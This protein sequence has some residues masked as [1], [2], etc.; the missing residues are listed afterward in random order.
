MIPLLSY[1]H[2]HEGWHM[3]GVA[4][5]CVCVCTRGQARGSACA[6]ECIPGQGSVTELAVP[7]YSQQDVNYQ[8]GI[9]AAGFGMARSLAT[10]A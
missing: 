6:Q 5:V 10:V 1:V 2:I 9:P 4:W 3:C 7:W 8:G